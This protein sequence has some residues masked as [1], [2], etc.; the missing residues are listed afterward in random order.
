MIKSDFK[1]ATLNFLKIL[2]LI[3]LNIFFVFFIYFVVSSI[4]EYS[5]Y[6]NLRVI[7]LPMLYISCIVYFYVGYTFFLRNKNCNKRLFYGSMFIPSVIL[8]VVFIAI[9]IRFSI[10]QDEII[11][12]F[13]SFI[14]FIDR[15]TRECWMET[16]DV[17]SAYSLVLFSRITLVSFVFLG[18]KYRECKE[19]EILT[20]DQSGKNKLICILQSIAIYSAL[21][22]LS[23]I[24]YG[25]IKLF[26]KNISYGIVVQIIASVLLCFALIAAG[27]FVFSRGELKDKVFGIVIVCLVNLSLSL[28]CVIDNLN[29]VYG[30]F[31][32]LNYKLSLGPLPQV[33]FYIFLYHL[34]NKSNVIFFIVAFTHFLPPV[35]IISGVLIREIF[36]LKRPE[37]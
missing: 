1:T 12:N 23:D 33:D 32:D 24:L 6:D 10:T 19:R 35:F 7:I 36:I 2:L 8:A 17:M 4:N 9:W 15:G 5:F 28:M 16:P 29:V 30:C 18:A 31:T 27:I 37:K 13:M 14:M 11:T 25:L 34:M 26:I 22:F 3:F 20:A 21:F